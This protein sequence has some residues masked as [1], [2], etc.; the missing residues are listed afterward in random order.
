MHLDNTDYK[1]FMNFVTFMD[2]VDFLAI[3]F[4]YLAIR[5]VRSRWYDRSQTYADM[6][7]FVHEVL[8]LRIRGTR[9]VIASRN[10]IIRNYHACGDCR[11]KIA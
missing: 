8:A 6:Y 3:A 11:H 10:S 1:H 4:Q 5:K 2:F 9:N 7:F